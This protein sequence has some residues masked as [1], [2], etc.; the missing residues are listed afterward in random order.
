MTDNRDPSK[1]ANIGVP[2]ETEQTIARLQRDLDMYKRQR[3]ED[4]ERANRRV[5]QHDTLQDDYAFTVKENVGLR[6]ELKRLR[7]REPLVQKL[8][9]AAATFDS[10]HAQELATPAEAY[11]RMINRAAEILGNQRENWMS[12]A[13]FIEWLA[14]R[15]R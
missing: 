9:E 5:A 15:K 11:E 10:Y 7:E 1:Y 14:G 12:E 4:I 8:I 6:A 13:D 3:A 2:S